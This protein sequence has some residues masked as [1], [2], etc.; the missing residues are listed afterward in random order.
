MKS[1]VK[2]VKFQDG[3]EMSWNDES[4]VDTV[5]TKLGENKWKQYLKEPWHNKPSIFA[6]KFSGKDGFMTAAAL[7]QV[8]RKTDMYKTTINGKLKRD[9]KID[10]VVSDMR[11]E[12]R[13]LNSHHLDNYNKRKTITDAE[14][15]TDDL[16]CE[17]LTEFEG[18]PIG[19]LTK[20]FDIKRSMVAR[21]EFYENYLTKVNQ[22]VKK[23]HKDYEE[24]STQLMMTYEENQRVLNEK[25]NKT[26]ANLTELCNDNDFKVLDIKFDDSDEDEEDEEEDDESEEEGNGESEEEENDEEQ[27]Q[28]SEEGQRV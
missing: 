7:I 16:D 25:F 13:K 1:Q 12:W 4:L 23:V 8:Q 20:M 9:G 21:K 18:K 17:H 19:Q 3:S 28:E 14:T 24:R 15:L 26:L 10:V 27:S 5:K 2:P 22:R 11:N 6:S